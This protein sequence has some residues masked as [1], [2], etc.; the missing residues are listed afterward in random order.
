MR[1]SKKLVIF[2]I[3]FIVA[4]TILQIYMSYKLSIEL[5]PTLTTCVYGFFGTELAVTGI[6]KIFEELPKKSS[7]KSKKKDSSI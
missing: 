6:M 4:Y 3:S 7:N 5:S 1:F 2:C